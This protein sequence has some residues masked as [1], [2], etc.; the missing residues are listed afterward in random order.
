MRK[1]FS[2]LGDSMSTFAGYTPEG[3][4]FYDSYTQKETGVRSV[5]DTWWMQVIRARGGELLVNNSLAGSLVSGGMTSSAA[6]DG[7]I[8]ALGAKGAPDEILLAVGCNDWGFCVLPQEFQFA[9]RQMLHKLKKTYPNARLW[10]A[11]L[12]EGREPDGTLFFNVESTISKRVYSDIIRTLAREAELS[13][14]DLAGGGEYD[15]IDGVHPNKR[16]MDELARLW[17]LGM[18]SEETLR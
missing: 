10:C 6:S 4:V 1:K 14:V 12:P 3:A 16:G 18:E 13:V 5:E 17:L 8:A 11:T 9:Y 15:T 2:I 7:R